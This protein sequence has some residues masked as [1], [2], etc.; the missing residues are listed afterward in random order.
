MLGKGHR[1]KCSLITDMISDGGQL[2]ADEYIECVVLIHCGIMM[3]MKSSS[4][5]DSMYMDV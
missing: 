1:V 2:S 5:G 4:H 3:A